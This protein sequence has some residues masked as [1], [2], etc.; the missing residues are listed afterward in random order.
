MKIG[1]WQ[2]PSELASVTRVHK[3]YYVADVSIT[4]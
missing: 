4:L 1:L 2:L 3:L